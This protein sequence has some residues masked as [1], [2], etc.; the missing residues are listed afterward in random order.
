MRLAKRVH[1]LASRCL[2]GTNVDLAAY[3]SV[4]PAG[5]L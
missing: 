2:L 5:W 3:V 4:R 1:P